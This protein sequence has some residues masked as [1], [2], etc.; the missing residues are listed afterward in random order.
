ME[1][2]EDG[3]TLVISFPNFYFKVIVKFLI[4]TK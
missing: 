2:E 1:S 3:V 4:L